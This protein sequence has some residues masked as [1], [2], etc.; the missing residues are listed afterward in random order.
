MKIFLPYRAPSEPAHFFIFELYV[1]EA[2]WAAHQETRHFKAAIA[3][4]L[5]RVSHRERVPFLPFV[6]LE[7]M[8]L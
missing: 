2:G 1:D 4:L 8:T 6:P 5:P 7:A 3:D